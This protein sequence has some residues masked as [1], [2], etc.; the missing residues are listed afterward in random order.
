[1]AALALSSLLVA[2]Y[3]LAFLAN[4]A[5]ARPYA[6]GKDGMNN[7]RPG[8]KQLP[9]RKYL[10]SFLANTSITPSDDDDFPSQV[11]NVF[12]REFGLWS[13]VAFHDKRL[14]HLPED[15]EGREKARGIHVRSLETG[16]CSR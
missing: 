15:T 11:W 8:N 1:M 14:E 13:E 4:N 10:D 2:I 3:T 16:S 5:Y 6:Q 9:A 7:L 12:D